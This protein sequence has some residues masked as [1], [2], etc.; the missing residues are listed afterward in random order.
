M[1]FRSFLKKILISNLK[2]QPLEHKEGV[3]C[4]QWNN[5]KRI[6]NNIENGKSN[7]IGI[8]R[9]LKLILIISQFFFPGIYVRA[10]FGRKGKLHKHLGVELQVVLKLIIAIIILIF[11]FYNS[12]TTILG[13]KIINFWSMWMI[14][15]TLFYTGNLV[16]SEEVFSKPHSNK[17]NLILI[18][19]DYITLNYDFAILYLANKAIQQS[20]D[21]KL[22]IITKAYDAIY[23]SFISSLTIGY[24]DIVPTHEGRGLA[25][26]QS[27]SMLIFGVLFLNF[28]LSRANNK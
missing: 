2:E 5:A 13:F 19:I 14:L 15:E 25:T 3:I 4:H 23:F 18:I 27:F 20:V 8:E 21:G 12:T 28:Y 9:F 11:G 26:F 16:F 17:R 6:W 1:S 10:F 7:S 24:G 22:E